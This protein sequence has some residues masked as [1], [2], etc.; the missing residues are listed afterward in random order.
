[1]ELSLSLSLYIYIYIQ[2]Q[3]SKPA[4]HDN[5]HELLSVVFRSKAKLYQLPWKKML[6]LKMFPY[7]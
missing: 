2:I 4:Q 5:T 1:M 7:L 6:L 3:E